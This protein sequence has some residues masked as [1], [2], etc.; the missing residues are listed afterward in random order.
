M[1]LPIPFASR[2]RTSGLSQNVVPELLGGPVCVREAGL[3]LQVAPRDPRTRLF[4]ILLPDFFLT[5]GRVHTG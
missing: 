5:V 2:P 3:H 4:G 1:W